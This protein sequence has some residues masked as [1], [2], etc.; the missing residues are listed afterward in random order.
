MKNLAICFATISFFIS[1]CVL[2]PNPDVM[3]YDGDT[4]DWMQDML[5][6]RTGQS[7]TLKDICIPRSHDAGMY[8][9]RNCTVG[10]NACNTQTQHKELLIN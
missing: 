5:S 1:S 9:L 6:S 4:A 3:P 7:I 10:A 8:I 2:N